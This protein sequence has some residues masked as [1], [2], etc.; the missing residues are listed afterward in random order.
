MPPSRFL[1]RIS[2]HVVRPYAWLLLLNI[3]F[4]QINSLPQNDY[5]EIE[6]TN[7][8]TV[9]WICKHHGSVLITKC[10]HKIKKKKHSAGE[11]KGNTLTLGKKILKGM[12]V[13]EGE[14]WVKNHTGWILEVKKCRT[15]SVQWLEIFALM[16]GKNTE[17]LMGEGDSW[18][19][20]SVN[21][22]LLTLGLAAYLFLFVFL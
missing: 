16:M 14:R 22:Q 17:I 11:K 6:N 21:A 8:V 5:L 13:L 12:D 18:L 9:Y 2:L 10:R 19:P 15:G 4:L 3:M 20:S 1:R 7:Y